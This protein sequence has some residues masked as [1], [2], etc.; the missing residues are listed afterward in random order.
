MGSE[1]MGCWIFGTGL[2]GWEDWGA[3]LEIS[4]SIALSMKGEGRGHARE[5]TER[6]C[7]EDRLVGGSTNACRC[8]GLQPREVVF[9]NRC[10]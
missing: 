4:S 3:E 8:I 7:E 1:I 10:L 6:A 9:R 5:Q 2:L